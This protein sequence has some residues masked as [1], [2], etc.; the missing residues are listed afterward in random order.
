MTLGPTVSRNRTGAMGSSMSATRT[1]RRIRPAGRV[2][3]QNLC[4][5]GVEVI[6]ERASGGDMGPVEHFDLDHAFEPRHLVADVE[7][8]EVRHLDIGDR[9][10]AVDLDDSHG[11]LKLVAGR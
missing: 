1:R 10:W 11:E 5:T 6:G 3:F 8:R 9:A 4:T 2:P 7:Q